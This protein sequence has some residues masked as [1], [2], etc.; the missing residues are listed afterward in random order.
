MNAG[1]TRAVDM[2][3]VPDM[4]GYAVR[5]N[6]KFMVITRELYDE[7]LS[8]RP[9]RLA[10]LAAMIQAQIGADDDA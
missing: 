1:M 7:L 10:E 3:S 9:A 8:A 5:V 6:G 4:T 2:A